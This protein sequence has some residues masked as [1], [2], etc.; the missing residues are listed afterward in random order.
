[1]IM[2]NCSIPRL[3]M[4]EHEYDTR[5]GVLLLGWACV[6]RIDKLHS[7]SEPWR[8]ASDCAGELAVTVALG[9]RFFWDGSSEAACI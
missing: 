2:M 1:M 9:S 8:G 3:F 7:N 5:V 4:M 6:V